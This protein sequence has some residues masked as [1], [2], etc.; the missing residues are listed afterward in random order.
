MAN[1][2]V[3]DARIYQVQAGV[4]F[5]LFF[6]FGKVVLLYMLVVHAYHELKIKK[7]YLFK[8]FVKIIK[9]SKIMK[10]AFTLYILS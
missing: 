4:L 3:H 7:N 5:F 2:L 9:L 6:F 1:S 8:K 10:F